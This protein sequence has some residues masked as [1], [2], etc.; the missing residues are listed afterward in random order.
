MLAILL[1]A[2]GIEPQTV[3]WAIDVLGASAATT[4]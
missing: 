3:A 2:G 1:L 4:G